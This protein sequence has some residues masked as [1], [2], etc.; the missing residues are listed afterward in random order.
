LQVLY[1][2]L[3]VFWWGDSFGTGN[4]VGLGFLTLV[5]AL[6]LKTVFSFLELGHP[7]TSY[8]YAVG[9]TGQG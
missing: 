4:W 7:R 3:R 2:L 6:A 9:G 5:N 8:R 1:F